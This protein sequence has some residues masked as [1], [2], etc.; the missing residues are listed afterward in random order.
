MLQIKCGSS[1]FGRARPCQGRGGRFE[2]GLPLTIIVPTLSGFFF[3]MCHSGGG[4]GRHAGL[5]IL[6]S[7]TRV[8]VQLPS[9]VQS[10]FIGTF[11]FLPVF[12]QKP[13]LSRDNDHYLKF[14]PP[15]NI[16]SFATS[17]TCD[18]LSK[19]GGIDFS[20]EYANVNTGGFSSRDAVRC[21][22]NFEKL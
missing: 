19:P 6:F 18:L 16:F 10:P 9:R 7:A 13:L 21:C 4:T 8:W 22:N 5:K 1:S 15:G 20:S 17:F 2:P 12:L 3:K 11:L 14:L